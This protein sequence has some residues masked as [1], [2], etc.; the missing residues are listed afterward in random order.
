LADNSTNLDS[1]NGGFTVFGRILSAINILQYFNSLSAPTNGIFN[2]NSSIST[3]P[4]N[5]DGTNEPTD[6]NLFYCDFAFQTPP[7]D[8]TPPTVAITFPSPNAAFTNG[9]DL[10]VQGTAQDNV[11]LAEVF[12]VL[13]A[14]AGPVEGEIQTNAA[15]GTTNWSLDLGTNA[16]GIYQLTAYA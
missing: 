1:Q 8:T 12:C 4:V 10:T 3:L 15:L 5:Y 9:G 13:T 14:L 2:L 16:P 11:G 6:A 7:V